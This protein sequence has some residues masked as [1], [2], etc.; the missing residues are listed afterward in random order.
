MKENNVTKLSKVTESDEKINDYKLIKS[1]GGIKK[2][3]TTKEDKKLE[4]C[5][6]TNVT[7]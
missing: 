7:S 1:Y 2:K 3:A 6:F 5:L 4:K